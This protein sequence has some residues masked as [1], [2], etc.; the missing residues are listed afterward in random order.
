MRG[1]P[2]F[3]VCFLEL[4]YHI[5][6]FLNMLSGPSTGPI[7]QWILVLVSTAKWL[8]HHGRLVD[9]KRLV[10]EWLSFSGEKRSAYF[11]KAMRRR[12][13]AMTPRPS[14]RSIPFCP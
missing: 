7:S 11:A 2:C 10:I 13:L 3:S 1:P 4:S 14:H 9:S 8:K 5:P 12:L 6:A